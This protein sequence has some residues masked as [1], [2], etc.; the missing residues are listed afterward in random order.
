MR[1]FCVCTMETF[2][3]CFV[4]QWGLIL[5][6]KLRFLSELSQLRSQPPGR[7]E[8]VMAAAGEKLLFNSFRRPFVRA[9]RF[10]TQ[11]H[12]NTHHGDGTR[13]SSRLNSSLCPSALDSCQNVCY[14]RS[15]SLQWIPVS[16]SCDKSFEEMRGYSA[17]T[18]QNITFLCFC[19]GRA[20]LNASNN[21]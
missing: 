11:G 10:G 1:K 2:T 7:C 12:K 6:C 21:F 17:I 4:S 19:L 16:P 3:S 8:P 18:W 14:E 15:C 5:L 13:L 9:V 20:L